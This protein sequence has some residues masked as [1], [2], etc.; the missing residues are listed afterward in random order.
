MKWINLRAP[1]FKITTESIAL[2]PLGSTEQHGNHLPVQTDAALVG[3]LASRIEAACPDTVFLLPT[4]WLGASHH[5]LDFGGTLSLRASTY[6]GVLRDITECLLRQGFQRIFFLNGHGGNIPPL[7]QFLS[8]CQEEP[9]KA[10]ETLPWVVSATY[11]L[12]NPPSE[13]KELAGMKSARLTHAC[14]YETSMMLS[15]TPDL[16]AMPEAKAGKPHFASKFF[17]LQG[18]FP[19]RVQA[20]VRF[21]QITLNGAMG[22][23][24]LAQVEKG[25]KLLDYYTK[26]LVEF[27]QEL[28]R[29]PF[30]PAGR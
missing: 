21:S 1:E 25:Q 26:T 27:V 29:W 5:H 11:W 14:E 24:G 20:G 10:G 13:A 22:E 3:E 6:V 15:V 19:S 2:V 16:V 30:L 7:S 4:L 23:P 12:M 17:A 9:L 18:E 8:N 28:R